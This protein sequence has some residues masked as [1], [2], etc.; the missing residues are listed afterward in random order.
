MRG[1]MCFPAN[2]LLPREV[3]KCPSS[4]RCSI[5]TQRLVVQH[6]AESQRHV[7]SLR[8]GQQHLSD[9]RDDPQFLGAR[10]RNEQSTRPEQAGSDRPSDRTQRPRT[11]PRQSAGCAQR[12]G[13]QGV[14]EL[15]NHRRSADHPEHPGDLRPGARSR[16]TQCLVPFPVRHADA[17]MR[18]DPTPRSLLLP[19][20]QCDRQGQPPVLRLHLR[21]SAR[22]G[23]RRW[24][25]EGQGTGWW[26]ELAV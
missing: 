23:G 19:E 7:G 3:D 8:Q 16:S 24:M 17:L 4:D 26:L 13:A 5:G 18:V 20:G 1:L 21:Y 10:C 11:I 6:E 12:E 22:N 2:K 15:R 25:V 9:V 14:L